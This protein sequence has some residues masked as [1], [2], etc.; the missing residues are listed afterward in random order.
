M[1]TMVI[2]FPQGWFFKCFFSQFIAV[3]PTSCWGGINLFPVFLWICHEGGFFSCVLCHVITDVPCCRKKSWLLPFSEP[4]SC[5][6]RFYQR[7]QENHGT[8]NDS[9]PRMM[10]TTWVVKIPISHF[11]THMQKKTHFFFCF[12]SSKFRVAI[13]FEHGLFWDD[14]DTSPFKASIFFENLFNNF[15]QN[16]TMLVCRHWAGWCDR[17][18][19]KPK[20]TP[21]EKCVKEKTSWKQVWPASC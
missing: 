2:I 21:R 8:S 6:P 12:L 7:I 10:D 3:V 11:E 14:V 15:Q 4:I 20:T 19:K 1:E 16:G 9:N 18:W 5:A 13:V 17:V